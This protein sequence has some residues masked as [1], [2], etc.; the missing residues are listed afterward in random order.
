MNLPF[1]E[2]KVAV[3]GR[4]CQGQPWTNGHWIKPGQTYYE[5]PFGNLGTPVCKRCL[6]K[7]IASA[8]YSLKQ[9]EKLAK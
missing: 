2:L 3:R 7:L 9:I 6:K 8:Q 1:G 4:T 5:L